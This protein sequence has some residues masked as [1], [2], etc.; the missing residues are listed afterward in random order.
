MENDDDIQRALG[1]VEGRLEGTEQLLKSQGR[2]I[3]AAT[4]TLVSLDRTL[5]KNTQLL[6]EH[7]QGVKELR[8]WNVHLEARVSPLEQHRLTQTKLLEAGLKIC[9]AITGTVLFLVGAFKLVEYLMRFF[10]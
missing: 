7:I 5:A 1:R 2:S 3:A 6:D 9:G 4:D 10:K 8:T